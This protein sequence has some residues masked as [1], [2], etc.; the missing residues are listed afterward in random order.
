MRIAFYIPILNV[1][2][3]EKV[4][5]NLLKQ[6]S[7]N[8]KDNYFLITD[9][10]HSSW[11]REIDSKISILHVDSGRN[12]F[13]RLHN[14]KKVIQENK[15]ELVVS[16]LTHANI[17]CLLLKILSSFKL[18]IVE[19]SIT[20]YYI[21]TLRH[22][23]FKIT[24]F[25]IKF[26]YNYADLIVCVSE[27]SKD[28]LINKFK[29]RSNKCHVI[30]NPIDFDSIRLLSKEPLPLK[31]NEFIATRRY[32]VTIGR[33]E[34]LK[35]HGFLIQSLKNYLI[36]NNL[37]LLIIGDGN[38][39]NN[40][41]YK[42]NEYSLNENVLLIGYDLNPYK[43]ISKSNLLIHPSKFEGFGLVLI[44]SLFLLKPVISF[45]FQVAYEVLENGRFGSIVY[46]EATLIEALDLKL[47]SSNENFK[48]DFSKQVY[49]SYNLGV[50][51]NQYHD[52][53]VLIS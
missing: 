22:Y 52:F 18:I 44:E 53:F 25:L 13:I 33:L 12:I 1:G 29:I 45:N 7:L 9:A 26:L 41:Q 8:Q 5:I 4:I 50:I 11:I 32:I 6:L 30:Y 31:V 40:L 21:K 51:S 2:G 15:I 28:D 10:T 17:H 46:D 36:E 43:F 48:I 37:V 39:K 35:N 23:S 47:N 38:E 14:I 49:D 24:E 3:A 42:I 19:H 16:H 20:S 27:T 34:I